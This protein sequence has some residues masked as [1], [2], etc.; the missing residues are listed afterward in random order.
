MNLKT[1]NLS[2]KSTMQMSEFRAFKCHIRDRFHDSI[3]V[4]LY[5]IT[6]D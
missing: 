4:E 2:E 3:L 1:T 5:Q 6:F